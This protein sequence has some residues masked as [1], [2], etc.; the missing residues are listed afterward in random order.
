MVHIALGAGCR[1]QPRIANQ[2]RINQPR[3]RNTRA[4]KLKARRASGALSS[5][6]ETPQSSGELRRCCALGKPALHEESLQPSQRFQ[7]IRLAGGI[8]GADETTAAVAECAAGDE[9]K[10][11]FL[12][13]RSQNASSSMPVIAMLGKA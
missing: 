7:D 3:S 12:Q 8:A 13:Q 2:R 5:G 11:F 6:V 9:R 1:H 4:V 10:P